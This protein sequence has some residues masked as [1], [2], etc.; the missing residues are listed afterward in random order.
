LKLRKSSVSEGLVVLFAVYLG[1][2]ASV[3]IPVSSLLLILV[4]A[5]WL[6][7][8]MG[9]RAENRRGAASASFLKRMETIELSLRGH[10]WP[11]AAIVLTCWIA[12][13]GGKLGATPLMDAHFDAKRFPVRA[14]DYLE[15]DYLDQHDSPGPLVGPDY[16]GVY[17]IYRLYPR[18]LMV[19]DDRHDFYGEEFLKSY[20]KMIHVEPGW[21]DFL[22]QHAA[23]SVVV[24]KASALA[25]ILAETPR[26]QPIYNDDAAV[27]FVRVPALKQ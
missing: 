2:Y 23:H 21:E 20:L 25:N 4:I 10:V 12:A 14:V 22:E 15:K 27:V 3:N 9:R 7:E 19:I 8:G 26:W 1:L 16:W 13:H 11:I 5:P 6:S 24:P 18:V 17:L